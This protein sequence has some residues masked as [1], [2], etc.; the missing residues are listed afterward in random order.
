[1]L[2][3]TASGN[4]PYV[5]DEARMRS[6]ALAERRHPRVLHVHSDELRLL[7]SVA[8]CRPVWTEHILSSIGPLQGIF[9]CQPL[10]SS[11]TNKM[12][13]RSTLL[14]WTG[15]ENTWPSL[16]EYLHDGFYKRLTT[17]SK[18]FLDDSSMNTWPS[19]AVF[20]W[21]L[22][23]HLTTFGSVFTLRLDKHLTKFR[24]VLLKVM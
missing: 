16:T 2:T 3:A 17:F 4:R 6:S 9:S 12:L 18:V 21:R 1:M 14:K 10:S 15:T 22:Y 19:F 13:N 24:K 7:M 20:E 11:H 23:K 5:S 8:V